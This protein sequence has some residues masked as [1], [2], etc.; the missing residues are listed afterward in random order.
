MVYKENVGDYPLLDYPCEHWWVRYATAC[1]YTKDIFDKIWQTRID[2]LKI[3]Y[4]DF[5]HS[6]QGIFSLPKCRSKKEIKIY[7]NSKIFFSFKN[8]HGENME[9]IL[10]PNDGEL[11]EVL[12]RYWQ[13][14]EEQGWIDCPFENEHQST[15]PFY[16]ES[17]FYAKTPLEELRQRKGYEL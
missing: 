14:S 3:K 4:G 11:Y 12:R 17:Q 15:C 2:Q 10:T 13:E 5:H 7:L 16:T 9:R 6:A 1:T 8:P